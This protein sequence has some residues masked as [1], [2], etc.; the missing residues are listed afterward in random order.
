MVKGVIQW[1]D[2]PSPRRFP[3]IR[4]VKTGENLVVLL[5]GPCVGVL[6]HFWDGQSRP[7]LGANCPC[8]IEARSPARWKGFL[9]TYT[10]TRRRLIVE[11]TSGLASAWPQLLTQGPKGQWI[12]LFRKGPNPNSPLLACIDPSREPDASAPWY[13][14]RPAVLHM[15]GYDPDDLVVQVIETP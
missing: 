15:W 1:Q 14:V 11:I 7:C 5:A 2:A 13:D 10:T 6:S 3:Q 8:R 9:P 4:S 12:R